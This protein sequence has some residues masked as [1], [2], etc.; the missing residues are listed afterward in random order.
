MIFPTQQRVL[1]LRKF[2]G[3]DGFAVVERN[4]PEPGAGEVLVKVLAASVQF[5]DIMLRKG[6][7]PISR[8]SRRSSLVTTS[9]VRS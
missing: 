3:P 2:G 7:Y 8:K 4:V 6:Q 9:S 5:T 1:M